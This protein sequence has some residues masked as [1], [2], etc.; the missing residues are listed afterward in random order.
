[1][2]AYGNR[3]SYFAYDFLLFNYMQCCVVDNCLFHVQ[4]I[5]YIDCILLQ[6][7]EERPKDWWKNA[8]SIYEFNA[9]DIDGREVSLEKYRCVS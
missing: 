2:G 5:D 7:S 8:K 6:A 1:M 9:V 4:Y 3:V